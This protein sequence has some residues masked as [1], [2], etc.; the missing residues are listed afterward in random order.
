MKATG[1]LFLIP[2]TINKDSLGTILPTY[3][4]EK[5]KDLDIFICENEKTARNHLKE[6]LNTP[7]RK[8]TFL[9]IDKHRQLNDKE[10]FRLISPLTKGKNIG[11]ISEAGCPGVADPGSE[12][13]LACH[14]NN[15]KVT[16]LIGPSSILLALMASGLNGQ[17]FKFA[18]YLNKDSTRRKRDIKNLEEESKKKNTSIII[19]ETPFRAQYLWKDLILTCKPNTLI[20]IAMEITSEKEWI[21]TATASQWKSMKWPNIDKAQVIFLLQSNFS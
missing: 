15:I 17:H 6:V 19:M 3:T 18:G 8:V 16:P 10:I 9:Q 20:T 13:I 12:I 14:K 4:L 1:T 11:L 2:T 5:I 21:K 7:V